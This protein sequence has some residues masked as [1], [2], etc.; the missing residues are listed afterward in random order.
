MSSEVQCSIELIYSLFLEIK[1]ILPKP[2]INGELE[3]LAERIRAKWDGYNTPR[4]GLPVISIA[5]SLAQHGAR[6]PALCGEDEAVGCG[7]GLC[8]G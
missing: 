4:P 8:P 2:I 1:R 6:V 5:A 7:P 3:R